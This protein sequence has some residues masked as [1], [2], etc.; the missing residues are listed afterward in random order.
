MSEQQKTPQEARR[1]LKSLSDALGTALTPRL[2]IRAARV[3]FG[4]K[5]HM[6]L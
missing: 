3:R 4:S 5:A 2:T 6:T 1:R